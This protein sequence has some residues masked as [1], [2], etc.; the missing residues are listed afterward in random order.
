MV[1]GRRRKRRRRRGEGRLDSCRSTHLTVL[2]W[3][4]HS[5]KPLYMF[6]QYISTLCT[7]LCLRPRRRT[8]GVTDA[9]GAHEQ[10]RAKASFCQT[11]GDKHV[12]RMAF[13]VILRSYLY[14]KKYNYKCILNVCSNLLVCPL[15][16]YDF[17]IQD[18]YMFR[19]LTIRGRWL[20]P[21]SLPTGN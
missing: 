5:I 8:F 4:E 13:R 17:S 18:I 20:L 19:Q 10:R 6:F 3:S 14:Q 11:S 21:Q 7:P 9:H 1:A 16:Q 12:F 15:V 2:T